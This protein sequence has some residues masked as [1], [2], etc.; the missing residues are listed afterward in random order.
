MTHLTARTK[1]PFRP[2][3]PSIVGWAFLAGAGLGVVAKLLG[4]VQGLDLLGVGVAFWVTAGFLLARQ[5]AKGHGLLDGTVWAGTTM[6]VYL[7]AWLLSYCAAFGLQQSAGF[8]AAWLDERIYFI[9]TAPASILLGFLAA[10]SLRPDWLGDACLAAPIA[11]TVPEVI[12]A[13]SR[14]WQYVTLAALPAALIAGIPLAMSRQR[15]VSWTVF[16]AACAAGAGVGYLL[17]HVIDGRFA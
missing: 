17:L 13:F 14:G 15:R 10:A 2:V 5:A 6:A 8:G 9:L 7:G 1:V 3:S 4:R 11:W 16:A 12:F